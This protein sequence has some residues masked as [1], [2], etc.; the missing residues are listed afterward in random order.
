M[1]LN[2]L[3]YFR[4]TA[5]LEH[6]TKA[7]NELHITQ[8]ALSRAIA[9]LE[10]DVGVK[11][12]DRDGKRIQLNDYGRVVLEHTEKIFAELDNMREHV[13]DLRGGTVGTVLL[14]SS[15]PSRERTWMQDCIAAYMLLYP[16][17]AIRQFEYN[18]KMLRH[19]LETREIDIAII[20]TL[21]GMGP[22][23]RWHNLCSERLGI[24]LSKNHRLASWDEVPISQLQNEQFYCNN[25]NSDVQDLTRSLCA[26]AG[27]EPRILF[28]GDNPAIIGAAISQG[29]GVSVISDQGYQSGLRH[30]QYDWEDNIAFRYLKEDYCTRNFGVAALKDR[31]LPQAVQ[32]FYDGLISYFAR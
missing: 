27:F 6:I 4:T 5:R 8:P 24:I 14:A 23:I 22:D 12:F 10:E 13:E 26:K 21:E 20:S 18:E 1:E 7:A 11:L 3:Q 31:Y 16:D 2:Q 28:E 25:A 29:R 17:V 9:R 19:A 30:R 15:F 32:N